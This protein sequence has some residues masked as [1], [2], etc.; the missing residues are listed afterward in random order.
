MLVSLQSPVTA[1]PL[2]WWESLIEGDKVCEAALGQFE[3]PV[4]RIFNTAAAFS[5]WISETQI[6]GSLGRPIVDSPVRYKESEEPCG[7]GPCDSKDDRTAVKW[8][9]D[10]VCVCVCLRGW[11]DSCQG[12]AAV[13]ARPRHCRRTTGHQHR[14]DKL[15]HHIHPVPCGSRSSWHRCRLSSTCHSPPRRR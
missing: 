2:Q 5:V 11:A 10:P 1:H 3:S 14:S 7:S 6:V 8:S 15:S 13:A 12:L 4:K 9:C